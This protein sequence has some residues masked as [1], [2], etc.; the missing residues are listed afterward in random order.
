LQTLI[1]KKEADSMLVFF[2]LLVILFKIK[3]NQSHSILR[4]SY[5]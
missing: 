5:V 4:F 2:V 3:K 1:H